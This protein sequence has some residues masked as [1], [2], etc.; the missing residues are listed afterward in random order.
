MS[1]QSTKERAE[2]LGSQNI[3]QLL[4]QFA[5][6][7]ILMMVISSLYNIV[8]KAFVGNMVGELGLSAVSAVTP[9]T[10]IITAFGMLVGGGGSTLLALRLGEGRHKEAEQIL[11]NSF[12]LLLCIMIPLSVAGILL[13]EPL[14]RLFGTGQEVMDYATDYLLVLMCSATFETISSGFGLFVRTDGS[15]KRMM[16]CSA[17]G[18]VANIILDPLFIGSLGM[19]IVGAALATAVSQIISGL[20]ILHYF[21]FS[22]KSTIKLRIRFLRLKSALSREI[23]KL[24]SSSFVQQFLGGV[25]NA[26]LLWSLNFHGQ[27][28]GT[29]G[30]LAVAAVGV[31]VSIGLFFLLPVLGMQ[32][33]IQPIVS[34][35]YGAQKYDR[36]LKT[37]RVGLTVAIGYGV[38]GWAIMMVAAGPLCRI[39]GAEGSFLEQSVFTLRIYNL[40]FP[41]V[42]ISNLGS[43][44]FQAVGQPG[45]AT[46]ISMSRQLL[47]LVP[48]IMILPYFLGM[49]GVIWGL[50]VADIGSILVAGV[51]LI[52]ECRRIKRLE[53]V[54]A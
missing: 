7:T 28:T 15:P 41:L 29:N 18:C 34:Y 24:G 13:R 38:V 19:G 37:L 40:L 32:Q 44:F 39:F 12:L 54:P 5:V 3:G 23:C 50:P 47:F 16:V 9:V 22:K 51:L 35:N 2:L 6:P 8:D 30:D 14:M 36:V 43:N 20:M 42:G 10:R 49:N 53:P 17:T 45:K 27:R 11:G 33:A 1:T 52:R 21:V 48:A 26:L 31:T 46:F 25:V 4:F